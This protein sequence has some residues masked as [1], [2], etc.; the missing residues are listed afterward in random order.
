MKSPNSA[1]PLFLIGITHN[2]SYENFNFSN[3][4]IVMD[5]LRILS[6]EQTYIDFLK[7]RV[8]TSKC[9]EFSLL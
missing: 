8:H 7:S 1:S 3:I 2:Y 6:P 9:P 4:S 5:N